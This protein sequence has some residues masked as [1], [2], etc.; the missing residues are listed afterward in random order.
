MTVTEFDCLDVYYK[1]WKDDFKGRLVVCKE[2]GELVIA[3]GKNQQYC[4]KCAKEKEQENTRNRVARH[5]N[6]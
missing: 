6:S 2:C 3:Q 5:R 4:E 1:W